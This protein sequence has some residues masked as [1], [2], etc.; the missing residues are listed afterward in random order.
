MCGYTETVLWHFSENLKLFLTYNRKIN[1]F[2]TYAGDRIDE[3]F[4]H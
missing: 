1:A 4:M 2:E 3:T